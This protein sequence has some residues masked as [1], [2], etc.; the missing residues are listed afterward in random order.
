[1]TERQ[2]TVRKI[3]LSTVALATLAGSA[4][5]TDLP[6]TKSSPVFVAQPSSFSWTGFYVGVNAGGAFDTSNINATLG[7]AWIGDPDNAGVTA[8]ARHRLDL[9]GFTGGG[10]IGYNYQVNNFVLGVEADAEYLGLKSSYATGALPGVATGIYSAMASSSSDW[11]VTLRPRLGV[12]VDRALFY[13]TGGLAI[14]NN[15]FSQN[16]SY[17]NPAP[18]LAPAPPVVVSTP[19]VSTPV[20]STPVVGGITMVAPPVVAPPVVTPPVVAL[21]DL[22]VTSAAGGANARS[23]SSTSVGWVL[24]GGVEYAFT[25]RWSAK[26]EYLYADP[27]TTKFRSSYTSATGSVYTVQ[28]GN[29]LTTSIVHVGVNYHFGDPA[30]VVAKY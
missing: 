20:V 18:A 19:V 22:P 10:Q 24:G 9:N 25:D 13:V 3:L 27:G 12:A 6:S 23:V 21:P 11:L 26:L 1:M 16:I 28:H 29:H 15:D 14:A 17:L 2:D 7:G 4:F 5:A 30:P 8:A